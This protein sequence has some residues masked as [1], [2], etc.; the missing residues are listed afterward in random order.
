MDIKPIETA[1]NGY[2]FRS[3]LE[4]RWAMFFEKLGIDYRYETEG[5]EFNGIKYLPDFYL[6]TFENGCFA[7]VK[8]IGGDFSK[9]IAFAEFFNVRLWICEDVPNVAIYKFINGDKGNPSF[10]CGIPN[11]SQAEGDNRVYAA[12]CE[13]QD[14]CSDRCNDI[15][16][17]PIPDDHEQ[18]LGQA[19]NLIT[20]AAR[21]ANQARFKHGE[22]GIA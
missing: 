1:Y 8:H 22:I 2:R 19:P 16:P 3:R 15:H 9:A 21:V 5:Y 20:E 17:I 14:V 13:F 11:F 18:L 4:A 10:Y 12:P 7:E 6:P